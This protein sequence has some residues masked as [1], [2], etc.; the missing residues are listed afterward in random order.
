[1]IY[2]WYDRF[3][4]FLFMFY[5]YLQKKHKLILYI[6]AIKFTQK[7]KKMLEDKK[8]KA[9]ISEVL[10]AP[11]FPN[12]PIF[13]PKFKLSFTLFNINSLLLYPKLTSSNL[14]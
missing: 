13:S 1:M 3:I 7:G 6:I 4:K 14:I 11:L 9:L 5:N 2:S 10:P 12:I 8:N